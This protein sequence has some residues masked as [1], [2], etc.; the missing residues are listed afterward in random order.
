MSALFGKL[1][2][3]LSAPGTCRARAGYLSHTRR[4]P[5]CCDK[6][7]RHFYKGVVSGHWKCD[8]CGDVRHTRWA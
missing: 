4:R 8:R 2:A 6:E 5:R 1:A 3:L 7:M